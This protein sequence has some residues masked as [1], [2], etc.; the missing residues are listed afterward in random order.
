MAVKSKEE[1]D[2]LILELDNGDMSK[3]NEVMEKWAFK[4]HQSFLRFAMSIFLLSEDNV[5]SIKS[6]GIKQDF[7]PV[8]DLLKGK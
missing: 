8:H 1:K 3:F 5:I 4:D 2:R 6:D 7:A